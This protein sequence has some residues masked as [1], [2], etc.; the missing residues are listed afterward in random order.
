MHGGGFVAAF[1]G[2]LAFGAAAGRRG[3]SE[4][5]FLEQASGLVSLLVRLAF[6]AI[7]VALVLDRPETMTLLYAVLGLTLVRM[8]PV[9]LASIGGGPDEAVVVIAVTVFL[10]VL[11]HGVSARPLAK[12]YGEAAAARGPE[13]RDTVPDIPVRGL[14][15]RT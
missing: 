3:P 12:R 14:P 11:A 9:A 5:E 4:L 2:G 15:R 13:P 8:V 10:S 1:I 6:G 7:A